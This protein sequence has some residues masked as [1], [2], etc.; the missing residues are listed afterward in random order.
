VVASGLHSVACAP[1]LGKS[2]NLGILYI[3]NK[4]TV[5]AFTH[6]DLQL[7]CAVASQIGL[8]I[9]N[10][11]FFETLKSTNENLERLVEERT[12]SLA[13]ARLKLYQV[14]KIASL[15]RL[16]AG[17]AHE[18]NNPLGALKSNVDLL[19]SS[20]NRLAASPGR[21]VDEA[22]T[23]QDLADLGRASASACARIFSVVR[24]L[25]SFARLDEA[26]FK[27]A[28]VNDGIKTT[29]QLLSPALTR[30]IQI[31]LRLG[32]VPPVPCYPALLNEAFMNLLVN[33]CQA[34]KESGQVLVET[35]READHAV[36]TIR[37]N[38]RGIPP[39]HLNAIFDPGFTTKGVGVGVGLGLP[40]VYSVI[41]EH[42]GSV[43][44]VST[45]GKGSIFT[46]RL[47]LN[48]AA[49]NPGA[50]AT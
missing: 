15:S 40:V 41:Q 21:S 48:R 37:D 14:E 12:A 45:I 38:G 11:K 29:V 32:E 35:K 30:N 4:T 24:S 44:V 5:G 39:E 19:T 34:I 43:S 47:P 36:I 2:G 25:V 42:Q 10:A 20:I 28:D 17:V 31:E 50:G 49:P 18:I 23:F 27:F 26:E 9:E 13:E 8:A 22:V 1:M 3:E 16:A 33:A 6:E 46:L 7:L